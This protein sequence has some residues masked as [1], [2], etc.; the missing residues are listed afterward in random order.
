MDSKQLSKLWDNVAGPWKRIKQ[1]RVKEE[2]VQYYDEEERVVCE[3]FKN[4]VGRLVDVGCGNGRILAKLVDKADKLY[5]LDVSL[6]MLKQ[7]RLTLPDTVSLMLH[8]ATQPWPFADGFFDA[9]VCTGNALGNISERELVV[10]EAFRCLAPGSR[11]LFSVYNAAFLTD[12]F[13]RAVY[14]KLDKPLRLERVDET[15]KTVHLEDGLFSHWFSKTELAAL[16]EKTGFKVE[17]R[18]QGVGIIAECTK[19]Q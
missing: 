2:F 10:K 19:T 5:G 16:L 17:L 6:E 15:D 7:A 4:R 13:A 11:A 12:D 1:A 14:G 18:E 3:F 9:L 8:D